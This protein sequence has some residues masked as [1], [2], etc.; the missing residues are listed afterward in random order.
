VVRLE[1]SMCIIDH[2]DR[3]SHFIFDGGF[4]LSR[5][6]AGEFD[7]ISPSDAGSQNYSISAA[8]HHL[9]GSG[10]SSFPRATSTCVHTD[11]APIVQLS[12]G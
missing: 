4:H 7:G 2:S 3:Y 5:M 12:Y 10:D 8:F 11:F 6:W 9:G 1:P